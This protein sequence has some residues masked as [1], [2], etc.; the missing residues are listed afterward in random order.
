MVLAAIYGGYFGAGLS[1]II[2]ATLGLTLEDSLTRLNAIQFI[3]FATNLAAA[4]YFL[5]SGQVVWLLALVMMVGALTGGALGGKL[6]N[7]IKPTTLRW[8]VVSIGVVVSVIYFIKNFG[9]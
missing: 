7:V 9:G 3:A 5:F 1:V 8:I 6:A 4:I 2:L